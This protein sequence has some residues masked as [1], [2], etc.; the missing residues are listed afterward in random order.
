MR[1]ASLPMYALPELEAANSAFWAEL[2][3]RLH[4]KGI[5]T[6]GIKLDSDK[7]PVPP[8]IGPEVFFT[9][10]CGYPLFK[11]YREQAVLLATPHY[12]MPGCVGSN[13]LLLPVRCLH[14]RDDGSALRLP[15]HCEYGLAGPREGVWRNQRMRIDKVHGHRVIYRGTHGPCEREPAT[16]S[17]HR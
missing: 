7:G 16:R 6:A 15:Q 5:D 4:A 8:G 11:H 14:D 3:Q 1:T 10:M 12:A 9:Q 13:H 2:K 17:P